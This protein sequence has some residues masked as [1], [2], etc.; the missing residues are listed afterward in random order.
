VFSNLHWRYLIKLYG[1][2]AMEAE[3]LYATRGGA[4]P[5]IHRAMGV[6]GRPFREMAWGQEPSIQNMFEFWNSDM[7]LEDVMDALK[8][9]T[10]D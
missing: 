5:D 3:N 9:W 1:A 7:H 10:G 6:E 8:S 2:E 4:H